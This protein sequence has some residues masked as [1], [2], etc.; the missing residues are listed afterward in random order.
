MKRL[1]FL[2]FLLTI[3]STQIFAFCTPEGGR[4]DQLDRCCKDK[5][6]D[7]ICAMK[8]GIGLICQ[9]R[10]KALLRNVRLSAQ[11]CKEVGQ[12]CNNWQ[13]CCSNYCKIDQLT[14]TGICQKKKNVGEACEDWLDCLSECCVNGIC[15]DIKVCC[16]NKKLLGETCEHWSECCG[17]GP[18]P[19]D[20]QCCK[21]TANKPKQC[22][23]YNE[24][25]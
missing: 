20:I 24:C 5:D 15:Q 14:K 3:F 12:Q 25:D 4:C 8:E 19:N 16:Q 23:N 22:R 2:T 13:D 17:G 9:K 7:L 11:K 21:W 6:Q 10:E 1:I 18:G